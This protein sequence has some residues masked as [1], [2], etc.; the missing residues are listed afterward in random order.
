MSHTPRS[1]LTPNLETTVAASGMWIF[2]MVILLSAGLLFQVQFITAK[3]I[4]P[5]FG[6]TPSVWTTCLLFFQLLLLFGYVYAHGIATRLTSQRQWQLHSALLIVAVVVLIALAFYWR[7]P[8][9]PGASWKPQGAGW[10]VPRILLLLLVS[11]GMP[12]FLLSTTGPLLQHWFGALYPNRSPYPLY[13]LSNFGSLAGLLSYPF[14]VEPLLRMPVQ[15]WLWSSGFLVFALGCIVC[16]TRYSRSGGASTAASFEA[17]TKEAAPSRRRQAG[18]IL[19]AMLPSVLLLSTTNIISQEVAVIALLWALPLA[20]YLLSF[21]LCFAKGRFYVPGMA[22]LGLGVAAYL[23]ALWSVSPQMAALRQI[24]TLTFVFFVCC[25][26]C[27]G[28]LY[29]RRPGSSH[30]TTFYVC[31]SLGG[32]LGGVFVS[33]VA[34]HIFPGFWEF[35]LAI[36]AC[37]GLML[38][39]V[40]RDPGSWLRRTSIWIPVAL[41]LLALTCAL[42]IR[43]GSFR[44]WHSFMF[45]LG[46]AALA[47]GLWNMRR[48]NGV[49]TFPSPLA[50]RLTRVALVGCAAAVA[51]VCILGVAAGYRARVWSGRNFY[52]V[53]AINHYT[54]GHRGY[55]LAHGRTLHGFQLEAPGSERIPTTYYSRESG[56][57]LAFQNQQRLISREH[58]SVN[59]GAIGLGIGT[60]SA[61]GRA[62]DHFRFYEINDRVIRIARGE[63]GHFSYLSGCPAAVTIVPGDARISLERELQSGQKQD[64]DIL[65]VD[66]FSGDAIPVHLL[67]AEAMQLYLKHL[68][69]EHSVLAIHISNR[70]LDLVPV[71]ARLAENFGLKME[72]VET[73]GDGLLVARSEW[74]L[75]SRD[76]GFFD[77]PQ[78]RSAAQTIEARRVQLWTDDYSNLAQLLRY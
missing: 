16:A 13:A 22:H 3:Y 37:I 68:R 23:L 54:D 72:R 76:P 24:A 45:V 60:I 38:T 70:S 5:W 61:Y 65:V 36:F 31:I 53:L 21:I 75:L 4:L 25:M 39:F 15:A 32:A 47:Y 40:I 18:W 63:Y 26:F 57:G 58:Q 14:L 34:P 20:L 42:R 67:T 35:W 66:A 8:I 2:G 50:L 1:H 78:M 9:L 29:R 56:V 11:V 30:L 46:V 73:A 41:V 27:H 7:A 44:P 6:G 43:A 74:M 17:A 77:R 55:S 51:S 64:F 12:F 33:L 69:D 10:E 52:G 62:G 19:L 49:I 48:K 71:V 59:V 28:E